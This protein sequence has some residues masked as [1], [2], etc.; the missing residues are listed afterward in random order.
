MDNVIE[1]VQFLGA[2]VM[3]F[4]ASVGWNEQASTVTVQLVEDISHGDKFKPGKVGDQTVF[5]FG[6]FHF[7]GLIQRF[8]QKRD[9]Q[10]NPIFEVQLTD[11]REVLACVQVI[12]SSYKDKVPFVNILNVYGYWE[13]KIGFG[14]SLSNESGMIWD[15]TFNTLGLD[16]TSNGASITI[17]PTTNIGIKPGL[18]ALSKG[19]DFGGPITLRDQTYT[20]DLSGLPPAPSYYRIGGVSRTLLEI[21]SELCQDAG[22]DYMVYLEGG[23]IKFKCVSRLDQPQIGQ[24][25]NWIMK[26]DN[27]VGKDFGVELRND[28]TNAM[29]LGGDVHDLIQVHNP[30]G[31]NTIW[32]YWGEDVDGQVI[33]GQGSPTTGQHQVFLNSS[34]IADVYGDV[35]Y[36]CTIPEMRC[37]LIDYESWAAFVLKWYPDKGKVFGLASTID[38]TTD[39]AGLF[40]DVFFQRDMIAE[41]EADALAYGGMNATNYWTLKSQRVYNF[42]RKYASEYLGSKFLVK[43]PFSI[44]WKF[45][46]ETTLLISS[47]SI[48]SDGG[49]VPEGTLPLGLNYQDINNFLTNDGRFECFLSFPLSPNMDLGGID[50]TVSNGSLYVKASISDQIVYP[51]GSILPYCIVDIGQPIYSIAPDP[52]GGI[53]EVSQLL[54]MPV[55]SVMWAAGLR[56]G[57][58]PVRIHPSPFMPTACAVPMRSNRSSYGPWGTFAPWGSP[59]AKGMVHFERDESLNP[60]N[61]GDIDTMN[62][63]ASAKLAGIA[64]NMQEIETGSIEVA[65]TPSIQL[66]DV[67]VKNGPNVTSIEVSVNTSGIMTTYRM[68]TYTP[69]FGAFQKKNADR[70]RRLGISSQQ[71]R[72]SI[73]SLFLQ[74]KQ[75]DQIKQIARMGF[76]ENAAHAVSQRTPHDVIYACMIESDRYGYRTQAAFATVDEMM[77]NMRADDLEIYTKTAGMGLEGLFRPFSNNFDELSLPHYEKCIPTVFD[78]AVT[79]QALN[80]LK[81]SDIDVIVNGQGYKGIHRLKT[82]ID[83]NDARGVGF[84]TPMTLTGYGSEY[85]G[86]PIPNKEDETKPLHEW[87]D[88]FLKDAKI[89]PEKWRTGLVDF[90]WDNWRKVWTIPTMLEGE[91]DE[92]LNDGDEDGALMSIKFKGDNIETLDKVRVYNSMGGNIKKDTYVTVLF[93]ALE[94]RWKVIAARCDTP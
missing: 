94:H 50:A 64:T 59:G 65:G 63:V 75:T 20:L 78:D 46:P 44:Y 1:Q 40:P 56:Y 47:N 33:M 14:G 90:V 88:Q 58:F 69:Q 85:T 12:L 35:K 17:T 39:L 7:E 2:T 10:G 18:L 81:D 54:N 9:M 61:Y 15:S 86:K 24:I 16:T 76:M 3:G 36:H 31:D 79:T 38:A 34:E 21:I 5:D 4:S 48:A 57:S 29:L 74:R 73:R 52:L 84:M 62:K 49:Y 71:I 53:D 25:A 6:D 30:T 83:Y 41:R 92:D 66:G 72:R 11:P 19:G 28:I 82:G 91:L 77:A 42:V 13:D 68:Q 80:P 32:P 70:L 22:H 67:L 23:V 55:S 27:A 37:A 45:E 87:S 26:Q 43:I 89:H 51:Q 93:N 8:L 60:W